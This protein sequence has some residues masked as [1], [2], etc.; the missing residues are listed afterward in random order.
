MVVSHQSAPAVGIGADDPDGFQAFR[1]K[2]KHTVIFQQYHALRSSL[3]GCFEML[4]TF[5]SVKS[6]FV[7]F[8]IIKKTKQ[9]SGGEEPFSG[10]SDLF[11]GD[12]PVLT[13][14]QQ[15]EL[16]IAAVD[17]TAV[18]QCKSGGFLCGVRHHMPC[19]EIPNGPAVRHEM[20]LKVPL[21]P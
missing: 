6:D 21:S 10:S 4:R 2:G 14:L 11:L 3:G 19:V 1:R 13:S 7:I 8:S 17:V 9:E 20:A 16:C 12:K 18:F 5:Q 15:M